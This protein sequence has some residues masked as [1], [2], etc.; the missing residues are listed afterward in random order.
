MISQSRKHELP[1]FLQKS[2]YSQGQH[3][4]LQHSEL[5]TQSSYGPSRQAQSLH[6][7]DSEQVWVSQ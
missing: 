3:M 1:G 2:P 6:A 4:P 5:V 7:Q